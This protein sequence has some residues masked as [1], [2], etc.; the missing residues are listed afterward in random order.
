MALGF[1]LGKVVA[2]G[3]APNLR[4]NAIKPVPPNVGTGLMTLI[5]LMGLTFFFNLCSLCSNWSP[6]FILGELSDKFG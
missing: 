5:G 2:G 4:P 1:A 6:R 3:V